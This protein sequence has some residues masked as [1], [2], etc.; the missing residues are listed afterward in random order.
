MARM[1]AI[2][3]LR[4]EDAAD[5]AALSATRGWDVSEARWQAMIHLGTAYCAHVDGRLIGSVI[6]TRFGEELASVAMMVVSPEHGRRGIGRALMERTLEEAGDAAVFLYATEEGRVLYSKLGFAEAGVSE[7]LEGRL[8]TI[9]TPRPGCRPMRE[10][11]L[12][13]VMALDAEAQGAARV[14]L[15]EAIAR[16]ADSAVVVDRDGC[17]AGFGF[18]SAH[19]GL[20]VAGP[21]VARD[22][23]AALAIVGALAAGRAAYVRLDLA[24][25]E[26][27]LRAWAGTAGLSST[28]TRTLMVYGGR[29]LPG[30]RELVRLLTGRAYG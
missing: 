7:R 10:D 21:V 29:A 26:R 4:P 2:R 14:P 16:E 22:D 8:S 3:I 18:S 27:L 5:C 25:G 12:P 19:G 23:N 20:R 9:S 28:A 6:L 13:A 24:T 15:L 11:D 30:R 17:V 1:H